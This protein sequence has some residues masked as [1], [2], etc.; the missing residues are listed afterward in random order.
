MSNNS[1]WPIDRTLS[2]AAT[3]GNNG[4]ENNGNDGVLHIPQTSKTGAS[5]SDGLMSYPRHSLGGGLTSVEMQS[6]YFAAPSDRAKLHWS[7]R[8][9]WW[10]NDHAFY[11]R[12]CHLLT[13]YQASEINTSLHALT[14][15]S[16]QLK[17]M[18]AYASV[19]RGLLLIVY[20][21]IKIWSLR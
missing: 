3:L 8:E 14:V 5:S 2:G 20:N 11:P 9:F 12:R 19:R 4:P 21:C 13:E 10:D 18:F 6:V 17:A 15:I 16:Y 7:Q 1:I